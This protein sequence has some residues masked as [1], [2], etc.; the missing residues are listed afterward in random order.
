MEVE[1][2]TGN[3]PLLLRYATGR[4]WAEVGQYHKDSGATWKNLGRLIDFFGSDKRLDEIG[5][6]EVAALVAWRRGQTPK[7]KKAKEGEPTPTV[8]PATVNRS[9]LEPLRKVMTRAK[10]VWRYPLLLEPNWGE[11][12]L[13]EPEGIVRELRGDEEAAMAEA[14]RTDYAPWIEFTLLT[15]L[16]RAETLLKWKNVNWSAKTIT[17]IGKRGQSVRTPI[18]PA[19]AAILEP[20]KGHHPEYIFTYVAQR[21]R[22]GRIKGR[23][24]PITY[25]GGK[26]E[27]QRLRKRADLKDFRY[28]DLRHTA[29]TR[30]LRETGRLD[31]VQ[32]ALNHRDITS[33]RRYAHT[34]DSEVAEGLQRVAESREKS[35]VK[36][37]DAA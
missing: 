26:T 7:G 25:E 23:R 27:W 33:T 22:E 9:V 2:R 21:T 4:Y 36:G 35:R 10:R 12:R 32:Q 5:D 31:I 30:L 13:K 34:A 8:A 1:K 37:S 28:H 3:G 15:G 18:T 17:T 20:L 14:M 6:A 16:R 29:G 24:Y 19:I 11:H